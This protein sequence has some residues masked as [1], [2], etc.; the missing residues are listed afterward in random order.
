M[1]AMTRRKFLGLSAAVTALVVTGC[2]S[3]S[4]EETPPSTGGGNTGG[5][6]TETTA[7]GKMPDEAEPH[8]RTWMAFGASDQIH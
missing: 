7:I 2:G 3:S 8:T 5:N 1:T 4:D 6:N